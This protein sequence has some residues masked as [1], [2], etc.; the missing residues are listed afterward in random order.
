MGGFVAL[1]A[2]DRN[3]DRFIGAV[4]ADMK[5]EPDSDSSKLGRHKALKAVRESDPP[6]SRTFSFSIIKIG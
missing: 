6:V 4:F 2:V 3:P 5:S 1:R